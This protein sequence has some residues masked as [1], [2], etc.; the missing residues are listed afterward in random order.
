MVFDLRFKSTKD[1]SAYLNPKTNTATP[2]IARILLVYQ[3]NLCHFIIAKTLNLLKIQHL[4]LKFS[5]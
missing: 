4:G 3:V 5:V 1:K 2:Q